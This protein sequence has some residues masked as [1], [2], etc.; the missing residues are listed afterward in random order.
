M[1]LHG[2]RPVEQCLQHAIGKTILDRRQPFLT[3]P[4]PSPA[5]RTVLVSMYMVSR[6]SNSIFGAGE[7]FSIVFVS[8]DRH[9]SRLRSGAHMQNGER[10]PAP[11]S[12]STQL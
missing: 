3:R 2:E 11:T 4:T 1:T 7:E 6:F 5:L 10:V 8:T 12:V 9:R